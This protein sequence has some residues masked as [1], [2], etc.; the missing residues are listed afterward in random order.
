M[1]AFAAPFKTRSKLEAENLVLRHQLAMLH[2]SAPRRAKLGSTDRLL[3][4]LFYRFFP[5][6][7]NAIGLVRPETV[8]R[9][10][11]RGFAAYWRW[12]S[13][14]RPGWPRVP[15]EV[16][17]LIREISGANPLWGASRIQGELLKLGIDVA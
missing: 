14:G 1:W 5:K 6:V 10:H 12:K 2:R 8:V 4:V 17:Q 15:N 9:W 11:R 16:R 7:L 13:R 3:F